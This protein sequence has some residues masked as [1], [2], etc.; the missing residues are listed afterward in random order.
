MKY[1]RYTI[2]DEALLIKKNPFGFR[3]PGGVYTRRPGSEP[4][5]ELR[6]SPATNLPS[7]PSL[8]H[9]HRKLPNESGRRITRLSRCISSIDSIIHL[10]D[11]T[12]T[13]PLERSLIGKRQRLVVRRSPS[14][15]TRELLCCSPG[16]RRTNCKQL[17]HELLPRSGHPTHSQ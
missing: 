14:R 6:T 9:L 16:C 10:S 13:C 11:E 12:V 1:K 8:E 17:T 3:V 7:L 4:G 5:T 2:N 15:N